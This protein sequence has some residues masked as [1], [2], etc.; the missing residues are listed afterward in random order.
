M[1]EKVR[2]W[3]LIL[4]LAIFI[5]VC[6]ACASAEEPAIAWSKTLGGT[7]GDEGLSVQQ[8]VDG[9][10]IIVGQTDS[11]GAGGW[12][13]YLVK[14]NEKGEEEWSKTFGGIDDDKGVSVRQTTDSGYIIV[15]QTGAGLDDIYLIKTDGKGEEEWNRTFGGRGSEWGFSVQQ[16]TDGGYIIVGWTESF[17]V[18]GHDVYL[19]KTNNKGKEE[20]NRTFG[21]RGHEWGLSVQQTADGGYIIAAITGYSY[22]IFE[23]CLFDIYL[24]KTDGKGEEEW[25]RTFGGSGDDWSHSVQQTTDGGYIIVGET[26]S[27][28]TGSYDVY[29]IKT[30]EKGEE[31]WSKT[32]GGTD[33]DKGLSVQ[34]TTDGGYIIVGE[35]E[36]F[37]AG[38]HDVYLVKTDEK[39][40]EEWNRTFG[41]SDCEWGQSVQQTTDGG[42]IIV[43]GIEFGNGSMD[44]ILIKFVATPK[45]G[46]P[47]FEYVFAIAGLLAVAYLLRRK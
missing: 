12:D 8:T 25:N 1:N 33:R 24:I 41:G 13:V 38:S 18:G 3:A 43:G 46:V 17:G 45:K 4:A 15:G 39:G 29:L 37:G 2:I 27:F 35:T 40:G 11:F 9:G 30:T 44:I 26:E 23:P 5:F 21:G 20:W 36:S 19:I 6:F 22:S 42:Y 28:G 7:D 16:T 10:Y 34:Q 31:E 32:F 47:G 14:T